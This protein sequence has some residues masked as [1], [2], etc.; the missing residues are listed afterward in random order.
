MVCVN[1]GVNNIELSFHAL[2]VGIF[3]VWSDTCVC[4][5]RAVLL[6]PAYFILRQHYTV[7]SAS[8]SFMW[9]YDF[10]FFGSI[11]FFA[12]FYALKKTH[13]HKSALAIERSDFM[14]DLRKNLFH[15]VRESQKWCDK[16]EFSQW[17]HI[18]RGRYG[19][20]K[21]YQRLTPMWRLCF[22]MMAAFFFPSQVSDLIKNW[23]KPKSLCFGMRNEQKNWVRQHTVMARNEYMDGMVSERSI[24]VR[25]TFHCGSVI[26]VVVTNFISF[27]VLLH[28]LNGETGALSLGT[29]MRIHSFASSWMQPATTAVNTIARIHVLVQRTE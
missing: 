7:P 3:G 27:N 18:F 13:T 12:P 17:N 16:I 29:N 10:I 14:M 2:I 23:P 6:Q 26:S 21:Q 8:I 1:C 24:D 11:L 15:V 25:L 20:A 9:F 22:Y 19:N 28:E 4:V 5:H